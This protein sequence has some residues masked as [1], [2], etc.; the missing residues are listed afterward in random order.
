MRSCATVE[1]GDVTLQ[2]VD[3]IVNAANHRAAGPNLLEACRAIGMGDPPL[4]PER[5]ALPE[6]CPTGEAR[7]TLGFALPARYVIHA[8]GPI[9]A[10]GDRGDDR[11]LAHAYRASLAF[12]AIS[13]GAFGFPLERATR[14]AV[15]ETVRHLEASLRPARVTFVC[16]DAATRA[17]YDAVLAEALD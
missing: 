17:V 8:V 7:I 9:W 2:A 10:G 14:I 15:G 16:F 4:S 13:V 3:A 1:L 5:R 6:G 12:P 11:L